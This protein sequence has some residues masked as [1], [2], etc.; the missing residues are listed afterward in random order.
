MLKHI[1]I[2]LLISTILIMASSCSLS[3]AYGA[4]KDMCVQYPDKK[5]KVQV[6]SDN[7]EGAYHIEY[8][9]LRYN[10][11]KLKLFRVRENIR[12]IP[13]D[14]VLIGWDSL[15]FGIG[16]LD[17]YYSNTNDDP[18]F[19]YIS[20]YDELY[21]RSDYDYKLDTFVLE[22]TDHQFVFADMFTLSNAFSYNFLNHYTNETDITLYSTMSPRLQIQLCL[23]CLDNTWYVGGG[24]DAT[25]F[26]VS[27]EFLSLLNIDICIKT[28]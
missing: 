27:N 3:S 28:K 1:A 21:L 26:E 20:R 5:G 12:E 18:I 13:E 25:L 16:Y 22:G 23:F 9:G 15:P 10:I 11:D 24:S 7:D 19:I 2:L 4:W 8:E 17:K 14:D 6:I